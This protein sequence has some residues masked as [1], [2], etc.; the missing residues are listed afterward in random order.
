MTDQ[1]ADR[2]A[3]IVRRDQSS[4]CRA[5]PDYAPPA[6][7]CLSFEA[8]DGKHLVQLDAEGT[9]PIPAAGETIVLHDQ[10]VTVLTTETAY[11]RLEGGQPVL[12]TQ[13]VVDAIV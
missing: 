11:T 3:A 13:V 1:L 8:P 4:E 12:Y 10:S 6:R 9:M 2:F 5:L 7:H